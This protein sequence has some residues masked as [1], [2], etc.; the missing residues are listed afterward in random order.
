MCLLITNLVFGCASR[1]KRVQTEELQRSLRDVRTAIVYALDDKIAKRSLNN[2]TYYSK[3][4][5]PGE[6]LSVTAYKQRERAQVV[7]SILGDRRPY[8]VRVVYRIDRLRG[9]K[10]K[11]DRYDNG[12]A[13]EYLEKVEQYL[14]SRPEERDIIDDF[15][16]Y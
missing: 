15:R 5:R 10:F 7:I 14:A 3:F 6:S 8:I 4:H 13:S 2:R 16:P 1:T 12:L 9:S 11:V